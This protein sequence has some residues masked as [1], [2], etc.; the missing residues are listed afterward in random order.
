[1]SPKGSAMD[2][3]CRPQHR[4]VLSGDRK[5]KAAKRKVNALIGWPSF[6]TLFLGHAR[7]SVS[8]GRAKK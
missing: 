1:M 7:K 8:S 6:W 4:D 5:G 2:C 3:A